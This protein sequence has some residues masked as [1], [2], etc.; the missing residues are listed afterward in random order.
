VVWGGRDRGDRNPMK[1]SSRLGNAARQATIALGGMYPECGIPATER[2][3]MWVED[4]IDWGNG[5]RCDMNVSR[6]GADPPKKVSG[7]S[8]T[9]S[10]YD[11]RQQYVKVGSG[12]CIAAASFSNAGPAVSLIEICDMRSWPCSTAAMMFSTLS[13]ST[14][15]QQRMPIGKG[16]QMS[17]D[18]RVGVV[19]EQTTCRSRRRGDPKITHLHL[20]HTCISASHPQVDTKP[21]SLRDVASFL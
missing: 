5:M 14:S 21:S 18:V 2:Y 9:D 1:R 11:T 10:S 4:A 16:G 7:R 12:R 17:S 3:R 8:G 6:S 15:Y 20:R 19:S 13:S